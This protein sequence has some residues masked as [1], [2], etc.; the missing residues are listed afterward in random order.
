MAVDWKAVSAAIRR[1]QTGHANEALR[2]LVSL[3]T[4]CESD[5]DRAALFLGQSMCFAHLGQLTEASAQIAKAKQMATSREVMLQAEISEANILALTSEH[6]RACELYERIA[7]SY[8]DLLAAD[9][10]STQELDERYGYALVHVKRFEEAV[11]VLQRLLASNRID[12][13]QRVR[14]YLGTALTELGHSAEARREFESAA[15][16]PNTTL[17]RDAIDR[18]SSLTNCVQ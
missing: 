14:L 3:E 8:S 7:K 16:G 15:K 9:A 17:S 11:S 6:Q 1:G 5:E 18:L 2:Q 12:D 13:E 10:E 4:A